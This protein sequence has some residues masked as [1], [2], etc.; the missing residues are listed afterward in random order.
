MTRRTGRAALILSAEHRTMLTELVGARRAPLRELERAKVLLSYAD[1]RS[2]TEIWRTLGVSKPT[3]YKC[4]DKALAAGVPVGLR[5]R[6]HRAYAPEISDEAKAWVVNLAC[7][8]PKDFGL[9]AELW[10]ISALAAYV[11]AEAVGAGFPRLAR[12]GKSTLWRILDE[13]EIKPHRVRYYLEARDRAFEKKMAEV[14]MVYREVNLY[15][16]E[17]V[18]DA[19]AQAIYSVSV[20]EKPGVQALATTAP[21]LAPVPGKH[22]AI[23]RDHEYVRH[24][25]LSILAAL[26]LHS[27]EIIANVE[28]RHRSVEFIG[29]LKRLDER[30][31]RQ[32]LIRVVLDNH[33]AHI[34]KE[35]MSYLATRPG[36]FEYVHTPKHGS[37][38]NLIESVFSKMARSFLR[39]IRVASIDELRARI[40]KG[41]EE[42]NAHPVRFQWKKFD[43][44]LT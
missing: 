37:W 3:I 34:S 13:R 38:L 23:G 16:A 7:C 21:D 20:D 30:Y 5:D 4:I 15:R 6:Y 9:A 12:A 42:M 36:R 8:K 44:E 1:G 40:L 19:R 32:A 43:F 33:S 2:P 17:A 29:L 41:I 27:G 10:T 14:L 26:D 28:D 35:T 22:A 39:H 11:A 25:T 31:P 18:H 24:G